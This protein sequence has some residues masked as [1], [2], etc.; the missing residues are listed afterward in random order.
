MRATLEM[1]RRSFLAGDVEQPPPLPRPPWSREASVR[2]AC[3]ACGACVTACPRNIIAADAEG[4]P[5]LEFS[6]A[7]C[8][9]CG[10]CAD[11]CPEPVF[12]RDAGPPFPH[13]AVVGRGCFALAGVHCQTCG[14]ACPKG[15]I[16]FRPRLGGPPLPGLEAASCIGCGACIA[17]C[18]AD[19]I[20]LVPSEGGDG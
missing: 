16:R 8:T 19:A 6:V 15:A 12:F 13:V 11:A 17:V 14:D 9:T 18:P 1:T 5:F 2:E 7:G 20:A 4:R 10:A 3:T